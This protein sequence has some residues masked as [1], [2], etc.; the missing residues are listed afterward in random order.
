[1]NHVAWCRLSPAKAAAKLRSLEGGEGDEDQ[2]MEEP[3][4]EEED[5]RWSGCVDM[6]SSSGDDALCRI[7][8]VDSL[9]SI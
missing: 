4:E 1:V 3:V 5:P 6:F 7:W 8:Q 9:P 2:I